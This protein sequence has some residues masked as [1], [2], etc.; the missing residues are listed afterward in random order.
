MRVHLTHFVAR[1]TCI[2]PKIVDDDRMANPRDPS[3]ADVGAIE[4]R[5]SWVR[6][7]PPKATFEGYE[8]YSRGLVHEKSKKMGAIHTV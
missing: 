7:G 8:A 4:V 1:R 2:D 3:L 5:I 6:L